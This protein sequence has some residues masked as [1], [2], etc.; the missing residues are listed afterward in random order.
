MRDILRVLRDYVRP[1]WKKMLAAILL[2]SIV[3]MSSFVYGYIGKVMV[4]DVLQV[5]GRSDVTTY[6]ERL[7]LLIILFGV[8]LVLRFVFIGANSLYSYLMAQI[9]E[10]IVLD[11]RHQLHDKLQR[12]QMT[13]FDRQLTGKLMSRILDDVSTIQS[14][15][16]GTLV[17]FIRNSFTLIVGVV[18]LYGINDRLATIAVATLPFYGISYG[19]L[20]KRLRQL[21]EQLRRKNAEMYGL[22][23]EKIAGVRVVKSFAQEQHEIRA[24][25]HKGAELFRL[26]MKRSLFNTWLGTVASLISAVGTALILY[27]GAYYVRDGVLTIGELLFFYGSVG[28]LFTPIVDITDMSVTLQ[29]IMVVVSR[30]FDILDE[31]ITIQDRP[32]AVP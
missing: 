16:T 26:R 15:V 28:Y 10:G 23:E 29:W 3:A 24:L 32:G 12:L 20:K 13:Y 14:N 21:S 2:T 19:V 7:Q 11:L 1:H 22:L 30:I 25:Y 18:V 6:H 4:D 5:G 8:Y 31:E 9:G 17:E 27:C